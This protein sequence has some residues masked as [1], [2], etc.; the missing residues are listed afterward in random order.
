MDEYLMQPNL[1]CFKSYDIRGKVPEE[2]NDDI[3]YFIGKAY[4]EV[5][6]P[7]K[8]IVGYDVRLE[9]PQLSSSLISGLVSQGVDVLNIGLCGT[10][11]VYF[12]T[13]NQRSHQVDGGIMITASHN[14]KGYNGMKFV[15]REGVPV[16]GSSGLR[17]IH[18]RVLAMLNEQEK[19]ISSAKMGEVTHNEDK[20]SYITHLREYINLENLSPL[21]IVVNPGNSPAG[22]IVKLLEEHLP[23]DLIY[24]NEIPDGN[25]PHGVPNPLLPENRVSTSEA[26]KHHKADLGI[27]WDGDFDRCFLFD[28]NGDFIEGYYIVGLLAE[29]FLK[30]NPYE[31][32][33]H[34]PR[35]IWNTID[36]V[37]KM[38]G[39]AVASKTGHVLIKEKMRL[40]NAIYGGEMSAHHY[41]REFN[42]NDSG[43]IP[44]LLVAE[45][46]CIKK[47]PLSEMVQKRI[48]AYPCSGEINY[49]VTNIAKTIDTIY[50]YYSKLKPTVDHLDGLSL[51]FTNWRFNIRASNTE[52]LIRLNVETQAD[53]NLLENCIHEIDNIIKNCN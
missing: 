28:E 2:L 50:Q 45:L 13:Y 43:M 42:Y 24:M 15:G 18:D 51:D 25:F 7:R 21:K 46:M 30:K 38:G 44:W 12:H 10:E 29:A 6:S 19:I 26:V 11:E 1:P 16:S 47:T 8:V 22:V 37:E 49:T 23:F 20:T 53:K 5:F 40:E 36:V 32:I 41:F 9:S 14:P 35:L 34:D 31:K 17:E 3:A 52:P 48:E 27:A 39:K 33:I 4:A